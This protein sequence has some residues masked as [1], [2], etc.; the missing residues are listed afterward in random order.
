MR[1]Y[2][3]KTTKIATTEE[4][5]LEFGTK[6]EF[7]SQLDN[8]AKILYQTLSEKIK[9]EDGGKSL[10]DEVSIYFKNCLCLDDKIIW[11]FSIYHD[12]G[13]QNKKRQ[14][15]EL[16]EIEDFGEESLQIGQ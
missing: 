10:L 11:R 4:F 6:G 7:S 16:S 5:S 9:A 2:D 8:A 1:G 14:D 3:G 15:S 12:F 13:E